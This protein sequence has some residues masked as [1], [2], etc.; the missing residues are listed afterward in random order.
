MGIPG[1]PL[2]SFFII[3]IYIL[4]SYQDTTP[5]PRS[6]RETEGCSLL[7]EQPPR[8]LNW[9]HQPNPSAKHPVK[10]VKHVCLDVFYVFTTSLT[11]PIPSNTKNTPIWVCFSCSPPPSPLKH[12][13]HA[14]LG[15]SMFCFHFDT[16]RRA[17][18]LLAVSSFQF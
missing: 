2:V 12:E 13:R 1:M 3:Y 18:P 17:C 6:K 15:V 11:L 16:T 4:L 9:P 7:D 5:L 14:H 8:R 10:H